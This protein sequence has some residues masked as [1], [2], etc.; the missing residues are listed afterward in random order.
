[1][2]Q[3]LECAFPDCIA[4]CRSEIHDG[5]NG[6]LHGSP[7]RSS[8]TCIEQR[9]NIVCQLHSDVATYCVP[10]VGTS[11]IAT[12]FW[13]AHSRLVG[14]FSLT[15]PRSEATVLPSGRSSDLGVSQLC[16]GCAPRV[17]NATIAISWHDTE[18]RRKCNCE[19][20]QAMHRSRSVGVS[21]GLWGDDSPH[22][23]ILG[24]LSMTTHNPG[25]GWGTWLVAPPRYAE[26]SCGASRHRYL[27][28]VRCP[29]GDV[30]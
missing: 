15:Q 23:L 14:P 8:P 2:S 20:R 27:R 16:T 1:M 25:A 24:S 18:I 7:Y 22:P 21:G 13:P 26:Q 3:P 28:H 5:S 30:R 11:A 17:L 19:S 10:T 12:H 29:K 9:T 4:G 6:C